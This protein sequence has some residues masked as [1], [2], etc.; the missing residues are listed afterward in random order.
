MIWFTGVWNFLFF[1]SP[2]FRDPL[3]VFVETIICGSLRAVKRW[4]VTLWQHSRIEF[5]YTVTSALPNVRH[6]LFDFSRSDNW[7]AARSAC[8]IRLLSVIHSE[9]CQYVVVCEQPMS[10]YVTKCITFSIEFRYTVTST[11]PNI[12]HILFDFSDPQLASRSIGP[13][14]RASSWN[15]FREMSKYLPTRS[16]FELLRMQ[17]YSTYPGLL[18]V[19]IFLVLLILTILLYRPGNAT[20]LWDGSNRVRWSCGVSRVVSASSVRD[21]LVKSIWP[22]W[23]SATLKGAASPL[24]LSRL[25][26][27]PTPPD[28]GLLKAACTIVHVVG[29]RHFGR[30]QMPFLRIWRTRGSNQR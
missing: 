9:K 20:C 18:G 28:V 23:C 3:N 19:R 11:L 8:D 17:Q 16:K 21:L 25:L 14:Y 6:S 24:L 15:T 1:A 22:L 26:F 13:W 4:Y 5:R 29:W 30:L 2:F 7:S 27:P 12:R 10:W